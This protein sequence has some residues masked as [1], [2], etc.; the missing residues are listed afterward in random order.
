MYGGRDR[1]GKGREHSN[2][3]R[4]ITVFR[5]QGFHNLGLILQNRTLF[6]FHESCDGFLLVFGNQENFSVN[7]VRDF[8]RIAPQLVRRTNTNEL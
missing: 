6:L 2:S 3:K 7:H 4:I 5:I 8:V 1:A